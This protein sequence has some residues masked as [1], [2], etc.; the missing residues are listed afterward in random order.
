MIS[1]PAFNL[2]ILDKMDNSSQT[3]LVKHSIPIAIVTP[4]YNDWVSC[5]RLVSELD[6]V[7]GEMD[8]TTIDILIVDDGSSEGAQTELIDADGCH[9]INRISVIQLA[10][11]MGHQRAIAAGLFA[12][13]EAG[14]YESIVIMDSDGEDQPRDVIELVEQQ[15]RSPGSVIVAKRAK[16]SE[17]LTFRASYFLY[18]GVYRLL[19]GTEISFGNFSILSRDAANR[20]LHMPELWN[21][22]PSA[23]L[24]SRLL[25]NEIETERGERYAG[26]SKMNF[27]N[28]VIHGLN[29]ISVNSEI[30][31]IRVMFICVAIGLV[32]IL[33]TLAVIGLRF[34]TD[35]AIPGWASNVMGNIAVIFTQMLF[36]F[37]VS[38]FLLLHSRSNPALT[39]RT[40]IP[41]YIA[42]RYDILSHGKSRL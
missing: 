25:Y 18:K 28:L 11:N 32:G 2:A 35:L 7:V 42:S 9:N 24:R 36:F 16:R 6:A 37:F 14:H 27:S 20:L 23:L 26:T 22:Y 38:M 39:P 1:F 31:F 3:P 29:A 17:G 19:T 12:A 33:G 4:V 30:V 40:V 41:G 21:N 13:V 34:F 15:R 10:S 5:A 8:G